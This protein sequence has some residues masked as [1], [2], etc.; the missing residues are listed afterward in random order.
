MI[1]SGSERRSQEQDV[2]LSKGNVDIWQIPI[3]RQI[4]G[5]QSYR[6]M[7]SPDEDERAVRFLSPKHRRRFIRARAVM[8]IILSRYIGV[9]ADKIAFAY[10]AKGKPELSSE[11]GRPDINFNLS[12][13]TDVAIL[14]VAQNLRVGVDI[15]GVNPELA[16]DDLA[17]RFFSAGEVRRLREL[18]VAQRVNEFYACW[19]R[20]EAYTKAVGGG[21][22][23]PL[24]SFEVA[25]GPRVPAALLGATPLP[26]EAN[27]WSI[28]DIAVP[29]GYRAAVSVEGK[30]HSLRRLVW[31][32][33]IVPDSGSLAMS[34]GKTSDR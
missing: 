10:G 24:D 13:S 11:M 26:D 2:K 19:T 23:V 20:K 7:L 28:Y 6:R 21:L 30:G 29:Q 31:H 5:L 16:I 4:G 8:R 17:E 22:S 33:P 15:E 25:F 9:A 3:D 1:S 18:P 27:C 12:H 34:D 32:G 14:A